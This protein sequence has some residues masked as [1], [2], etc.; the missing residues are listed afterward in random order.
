MSGLAHPIRY[1]PRFV[2]VAAMYVLADTPSLASWTTFYEIVGCSGGALVG[3]QFVVIALI[4]N[5]RMRADFGA[6]NAFGT[7]NVVHFAAALT[8]SAIMS[9]PWPSM[10]DISIATALCGIIGLAYSATV[11]HRAGHQSAYKPVFEDW[12][13][14]AILPCAIYTMLIAA[15]VL[16]QLSNR[17]GPLMVAGTALGLL[18]TGIRNSWDSVTHI[19]LSSAKDGDKKTE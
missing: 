7:P 6:I 16:L 13:F 5:T 3:L 11:F 4:A 1:P 8:I 14:Y 10:F 9:A 12:L 15:A 19:V 17:A 2:Y 18:L